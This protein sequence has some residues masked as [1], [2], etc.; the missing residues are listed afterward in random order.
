MTFTISAAITTGTT[1]VMFTNIILGFIGV[2]LLIIA[3]ALCAIERIF[4]R[5]AHLAECKF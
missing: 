1:T 5:I 4:K 3:S 2:I